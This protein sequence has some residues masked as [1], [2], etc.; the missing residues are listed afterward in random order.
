MPVFRARLVCINC[1]RHLPLSAYRCPWC[2]THANGA[3]YA[4]SAMRD[5]GAHPPVT[6]L[7]GEEV[8]E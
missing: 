5:R 7:Y 2:N 6:S 8:R 4:S 1:N 3:R